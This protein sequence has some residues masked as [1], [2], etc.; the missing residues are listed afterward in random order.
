MATVKAGLRG[1]RNQ[2][3]ASRINGEV[4]VKS[5]YDR[6]AINTIWTKYQASPTEELRNYLMERFLPLVRYNA[7]R[8]HTRLPDEV[9]VE[10][11]MSAGVFGLMDAIDAFDLERSR[12][13][14]R[15]AFAGQFSTSCAAWTGCRGWCVIAAARSIRL[16]KKSKS[17]RVGLR[18]KPR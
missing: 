7:E 1:S 13:I 17:A 15:R 14:V 9:D 18:L 16:V 6:M 4:V 8:I 12:H 10:D 2:W 3:C 11:L 5:K